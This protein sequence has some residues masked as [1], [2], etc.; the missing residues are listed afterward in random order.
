MLC[1]MTVISRALPFELHAL[2]LTTGTLYTALILNPLKLSRLF[3]LET[4]SLENKKN[5]QFL[6]I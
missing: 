4:G 2:K 1:N 6:N 5:I 3:H